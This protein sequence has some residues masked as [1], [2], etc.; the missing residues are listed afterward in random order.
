MCAIALS[1]GKRTAV[2]LEL[3]WSEKITSCLIIINDNEVLFNYSSHSK[4]SINIFTRMKMNCELYWVFYKYYLRV[5]KC[6]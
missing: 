6:G 2:N 4:I 1:L 5:T 3:P